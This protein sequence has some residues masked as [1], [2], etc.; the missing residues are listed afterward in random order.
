MVEGKH[1]TISL[2]YKVPE[3]RGSNDEFG[4]SLVRV[5]LC[6]YERIWGLKGRVCDVDILNDEITWSWGASVH[7]FKSTKGDGISLDVEEVD[8]F[9]EWVFTC[10]ITNNLLY[11]DEIYSWITLIDVSTVCEVSI[12]DVELG[13][14]LDIYVVGILK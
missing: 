1:I 5:F 13:S 8:V 7:F 4:N 10:I 3:V 12:E 9:H 14:H 11:I 2:K 6:L